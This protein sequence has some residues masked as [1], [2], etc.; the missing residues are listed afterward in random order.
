MKTNSRH[1]LGAAKYE[2][3]TPAQKRPK[4]VAN[5]FKVLVYGMEK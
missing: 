4:M 2:D 3:S 1:I 5:S